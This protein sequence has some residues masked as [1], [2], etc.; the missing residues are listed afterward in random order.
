MIS[1]LLFAYYGMC[2]IKPLPPIGCDYDDA[3]CIC[4]SSRNCYWV[5]ICN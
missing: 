2:P 3:V 5:W 4:D 1:I